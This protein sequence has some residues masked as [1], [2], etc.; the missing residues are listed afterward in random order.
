MPRM[1]SDLALLQLDSASLLEALDENLHKILVEGTVEW[2]RT[3]AA[4]LPNWSGESRASLKPIADLVNV[5]IFV[6]TVPGAPNRQAQGLAAGFAELRT[7]DGIYT[8][9]WRSDVF[10]LAYNEANNANL[11]GFHLRNPGP[12]NSQRQAEQS[13]FLTI[14]PRLRELQFGIDKFIKVVRKK[15]G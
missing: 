5:P 13:F 10:H 15:N 2:V 3:V 7:T 11:V 1:T 12:Y 6:T 8:F 14:N 9:E 4:I